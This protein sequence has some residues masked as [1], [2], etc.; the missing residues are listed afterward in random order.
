[1]FM[2][3]ELMAIFWKHTSGQTGTD[4]VLTVDL[5]YRDNSNQYKTCLTPIYEPYLIAK[6]CAIY[7]E[8]GYLQK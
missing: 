2:A 4:H 7:A 3:S 1:M 5:L 8:K 6:S